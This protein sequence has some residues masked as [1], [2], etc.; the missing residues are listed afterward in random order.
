MPIDT[1]VW[2]IDGDVRRIHPQPLDFEKRLE[3]ILD[4]DITIASPNWLVIGRQVSTAHGKFIDLLAMDPDGNLI[5]VELKRD[6]TYRDIVAQVLDYGSWIRS[7]QDDQLQ[8]IY[9]DYVRRYRTNASSDSLDEAFKARF[10]VSRLPDELNNA[11]ELVIVASELDPSTER[12]VDYLADQ[13]GVQINAIFFRVYRDGDAEFLVRAWLRAPTEVAT[14]TEREL[15]GSSGEWNREYYVSFGHYPGHRDWAEARR[16]GFVS[17]GGGPW[18]TRTLNMLEPGAR[19]WVNIPQHGYAGVAEVTESAV[20]IDEF[21][22]RD[23]DGTSTRLLDVKDVSTRG[24]ATIADDPETA[25]YVVRVKWIHTVPLG[26]AVREK[27]FFGNQ[28]TV[29]QPRSGKWAHTIERLKKRFDLS[30]DLR[31][32]PSSD[33]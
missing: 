13:Y 32:G 33:A 21:T 16:Y 5:V 19:I 7:L 12:I 18:Y 8:R 31:T 3:D 4:R 20:P 15:A 28:N 29:A 17:A 24:V 26:E 11:H 10:A 25:E 2:R 14:P 22:I 27:G 6:R 30:Q 1:G 9:Q 23:D